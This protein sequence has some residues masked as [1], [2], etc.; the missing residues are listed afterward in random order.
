[1][2]RWLDAAAVYRD[3]RMALI[4]VLGF[5]SGLPLALSFGTLSAWL[6]STGIDRTTIGLFALMGLPAENSDPDPAS[7]SASQLDGDIS[8][9]VVSN[10][11]RPGPDQSRDGH[12]T[13]SPFGP[14]GGLFI[15]NPGHCD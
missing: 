4:G 12:W 14:D 5:S 13:H 2:G 3:P 6:A 8:A 11:H 1:M 10:H 9:F 7:G 15:G